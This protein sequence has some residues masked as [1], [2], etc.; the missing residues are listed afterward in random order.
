MAL[1]YDVPVMLGDARLASEMADAMLKRGV[2]VIGFSF[3]VV[4]VGKARIRC[5][6]SASHTKEQI[7]QSVDAFIEVGKEFGVIQ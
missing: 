6:V 5:Q 2:F 7:D 3:P 1:Q 4:P